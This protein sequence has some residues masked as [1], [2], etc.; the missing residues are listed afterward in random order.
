MLH[1]A[2][3]IALRMSSTRGMYWRVKRL[4]RQVI[5]FAVRLSHRVPQEHPQVTTFFMKYDIYAVITEWNKIRVA[6][7]HNIRDIVESNLICGER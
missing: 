5:N 1:D 6:I 3:Y 2:W 7:D 4:I